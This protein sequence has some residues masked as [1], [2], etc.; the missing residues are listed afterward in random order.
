MVEHLIAESLSK[1]DGHEKLL[2]W[3]EE[4]P[5]YGANFT[6]SPGS[7]VAFREGP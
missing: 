7:V 2:Q 1:A 3:A 5:V 4:P 6:A